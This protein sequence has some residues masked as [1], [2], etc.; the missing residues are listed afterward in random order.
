M[1]KFVSFSIIIV[2]QILFL[3]GCASIISKST[4]PV[5]ISSQPNGAEISITNRK[6]LQIYTGQTPT[7][8]TLKAGRPY[9]I[10]EKYTV[11]FKKEDIR[12]LWASST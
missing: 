2:L 9:F 8:I 12:S 6:G 1:K 5:T 3:T 11:T 4:Y 7:T 10:F